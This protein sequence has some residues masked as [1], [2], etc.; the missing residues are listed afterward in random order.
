MA[1]RDRAPRPALRPRGPAR[2]RGRGEP[3]VHVVAHDVL[4]SWSRPDGSGRRRRPCRAVAAASRS[5]TTPTDRHGEAARAHAAH[6]D[7][8]LASG[9]ADRRVRNLFR[10]PR[11]VG[12]VLAVFFRLFFAPALR[13]PGAGPAARTRSGCASRSS[14]WAAPGS[15]SAR[16]WPCASTCCRSPYCDELFR[17]LNEVAPFPYDE[18]REI[19]RQELGGEPEAVFATF[20]RQS[21][22]AASIGQVHRAILHTGDRVAVK[23]QR[24]HI[25]ET[26]QADIDLM[27]SRDLAARLVPLFGGDQE[28]RGHR[29]VRP[30]D[31]RRAR[32]PRRGPPGRPAPRARAGRPVRADR[33]R[34]PRLHDLARA[35]RP[36]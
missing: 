30:L 6:V 25:R 16:C 19:V 4:A 11:R 27:Y 2:R 18:V 29:R 22:A 8:R 12:R 15:S 36:S 3:A 14:S 20:E 23:V 26:L 17:L 13:L 9:S 21:F 31:R 35:D 34:L 10:H 28:P 33:P 32:L 5:M 24:P 1:R 7:G